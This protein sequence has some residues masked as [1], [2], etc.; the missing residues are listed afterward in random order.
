MSSRLPP[1]LTC[2]DSLLMVCCTYLRKFGLLQF[3][4]VYYA[5]LYK[6]RCATL[7]MILPNSN[8]RYFVQ[9]YQT[10]KT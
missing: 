10:I 8:A 5:V 2:Q 4:I 3:S 9:A 7:C 1:L 6:N